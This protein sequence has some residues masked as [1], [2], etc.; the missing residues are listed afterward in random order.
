MA[1]DTLHLLVFCAKDKVSRGVVKLGLVKVS[2]QSRA[3]LVVGM[4]RST[5]LRLHLPVN[6]RLASHIGSYLLVA[7]HAQAILGLAVKLGMALL[8]LVVHFR[9]GLRQFSGGNNGLNALRDSS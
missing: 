9:M 8:A 1:L 3:S 5:S 6:A 4:T 7:L 2:N